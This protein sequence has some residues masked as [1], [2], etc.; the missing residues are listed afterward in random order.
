MPADAAAP[1]AANTT[2]RVLLVD[3]DP[4]MRLLGAGCSAKR[5]QR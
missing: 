5:A 2:P 4:I 1:A 3:D